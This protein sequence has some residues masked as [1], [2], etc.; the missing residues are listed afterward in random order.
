MSARRQISCRGTTPFGI[1]F[2]FVVV[3]V[4]VLGAKAGVRYVPRFVGTAVRG[5][6]KWASLKN[7]FGLRTVLRRWVM[8]S[9]EGGRVVI[10][11]FPM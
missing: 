8:R 10:W 6:R 9:K 7:G 5:G 1:S 3:F 2:V 11:L 4:L